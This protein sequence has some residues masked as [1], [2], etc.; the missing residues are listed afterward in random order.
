MRVGAPARHVWDDGVSDLHLVET[1]S[2]L[3]ELPPIPPPALPWRAPAEHPAPPVAQTASARTG[4]VDLGA[5]AAALRRADVLDV[6]PIAIPGAVVVL[7]Y[8]MAILRR[9]EELVRNHYCP[10]GYEEYDYPLLAPAQAMEPTRQLLDLQGR[11]LHVGTDT[12]WANG[13]SR[14]VLTPTGE[15]SVYTHWAGIVRNRGDLPIRMY[16]RARYF[17]PSDAGRSIFRSV[18]AADVYE[19][20]ACLATAEEAGREF[21]T[22][23]DM[24]RRL[25]AAAHVPVL[26]TSRP[27]WTNNCRV[28]ATT[29]G[30]D[31]PLPNGSTLQVGCLYD[32]GQRFSQQYGIAWRSDS[33][34]MYT[35]HVTGAVTRRLVLAHLLLGLDSA[36]DLLI[37]PS[38]V[39]VQV[40]ATLVGGTDAERAQAEETAR[41]L[42]G[43]GLR[44]A[45]DIGHDRRMAGRL[46]RM[47]QTRGV[48][49]RIHLQ[50]ARHAG[51]GMRIVVVRADTRE[52][53]VLSPDRLT[54]L[55]EP[56]AA[57]VHAVGVGYARRARGFTARQIT[58]VASVAD[59]RAVLAAR[60]IAR[61][62]LAPTELA[63]RAVSS[64]RSG[65]VLG[66]SPSN[67][68]SP[69]LVTGA[70]THA[71]AYLSPRT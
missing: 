24:V 61:C 9:F 34:R 71:V 52:E 63:A 3:T 38:L 54:D 53:A 69:C 13:T 62:H 66:W 30:G 33:T 5:F 4:W 60:G 17:R 67:A 12:D 27:L 70:R 43:L 25:C 18:E 31:A 45:L 6:E 47:W 35:H 10:A 40:A 48:P 49:L 11:L 56:L 32:Q 8:G 41:A 59:A 42:T 20:H 23:L 2:D 22:A 65:E 1:E 68:E 51:E 64:W 44:V 46:H 39:P 7:P 21:A 15:A 36:G 19:F 58:T 14:M 57:S 55:V 29:L 26:W 16:R 37:H 28:S 50:P